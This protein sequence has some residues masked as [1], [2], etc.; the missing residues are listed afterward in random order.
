MSNDMA[1]E[2]LKRLTDQHPY[3]SIGIWVLL[4]IIITYWLTRN[5][6]NEY[7]TMD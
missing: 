3:I 6:K 5:E 4:V 7:E 1:L 2:G